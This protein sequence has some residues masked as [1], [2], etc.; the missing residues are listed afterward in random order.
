MRRSRA[1]QEIPGSRTQTAPISQF[2]RHAITNRPRRRISSGRT[3]APIIADGRKTPVFLGFD[4]IKYPLPGEIM[5]EIHWRG[6]FP[7][8]TT[9]FTADDRLD[10][11][12]GA[13]PGVSA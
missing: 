5:S 1:L 3:A 11:C 6:V 10:W 9:K 8:L 7:A 13:A 4:I 2:C 12:H